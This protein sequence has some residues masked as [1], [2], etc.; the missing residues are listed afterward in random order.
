MLDTKDT[1]GKHLS[2]FDRT[3]IEDALTNA[4]PLHEIAKRLGKDP[5]TIS[6]EVKRN[7][8]FR[9]SKTE[10]KGGCINR[11]SCQVKHLCSDACN[12]LC[13]SCIDL[14]CMRK[15]NNFKPKACNRLDKFPHVCN[16]CESKYACKLDKHFYSAKLAEANY[17][18]KLELSRQ[19]INMTSSE[20]KALDNLISPLIRM[21][22]PIYHIYAN[23]KD[24][25]KCSERTLYHYIENGLLSVRNIDLRR[26][27]KYKPRKKKEILRA[28]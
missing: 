25:I 9:Q 19:G 27:V 5:R 3:F 8:T 11:R 1:K 26:K 21:G 20:L 28:K 18:E 14:N 2:N 22:Q 16:G 15:C 17:R 4:Y 12:K 23:H 6:K 7:R 10:F 24:E 13:R